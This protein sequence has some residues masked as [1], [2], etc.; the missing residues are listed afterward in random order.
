[1]LR[2]VDVNTKTA[3]VANSAGA[4]VKRCPKNK[5]TY[6]SCRSCLSS[7]ENIFFFDFVIYI[8]LRFYFDNFITD[9]VI[10]A[11]H[12]SSKSDVVNERTLFILEGRYIY[13]YGLNID[14]DAMTSCLREFT[15]IKD[16]SNWP[17]VE[18][19]S[20]YCK[21]KAKAQKRT[22]FIEFVCQCTFLLMYMSN[23]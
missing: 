12:V 15:C 3:R 9:H 8:S 13:I 4:A 19:N 14:A 22:R 20:T 18:D 11:K 23:Y 6:S 2:I 10:R 17:F 1:M 5:N 16:D 21:T 7:S